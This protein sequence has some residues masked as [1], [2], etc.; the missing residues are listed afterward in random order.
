MLLTYILVLALAT[1][2]NVRA[3][4]GIISQEF[5]S[6]ESC[7]VAGKSLV[8]NTIKRGNYVVTWGCFKK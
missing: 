4:M 2:G 5:T 7:E 1:S 3:G 8:E 6:K